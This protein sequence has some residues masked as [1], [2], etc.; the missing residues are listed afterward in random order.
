MK[1][2]KKPKP[3]SVLNGFLYSF[4]ANTLFGMVPEMPQSYAFFLNLQTFF[5]YNTIMKAN[6]KKSN[7]K[8]NNEAKTTARENMSNREENIKTNSMRLVQLHD[9]SIYFEQSILLQERIKENL[10][11]VGIELWVSGRNI[12]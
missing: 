4:N 6:P 5:K 1:P 3:L 2:I 9:Q 8:Q 12:N 11:K 7:W 10:K